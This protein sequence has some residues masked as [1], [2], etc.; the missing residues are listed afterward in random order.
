MVVCRWEK[1]PRIQDSVRPARDTAILWFEP[2][3]HIRGANEPFL[4]PTDTVLGPHGSTHGLKGNLN[5]TQIVV[6]HQVE[7]R[8]LLE[9]LFLVILAILG[10]L[11]AAPGTATLAAGT[12]ALRPQT[13]TVCRPPAILDKRSNI[14]SPFR[15]PC[16]SRP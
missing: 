9:P 6:V 14:F 11:G 8:N 4:G 13:L 2:A 15:D 10:L 3:G 1:C 5:S 7:Q 12:R 16:C